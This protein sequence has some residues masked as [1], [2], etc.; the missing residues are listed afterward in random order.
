M[1]DRQRD[2]AARLAMLV[3]AAILAAV[4]ARAAWVVDE[5]GRCVERW[6]ADDWA[7]GP[8]AMLD[9]P[10]VPV[11]FASDAAGELRHSEAPTAEKALYLPVVLVSGVQAAL[12]QLFSGFADTITAGRFDLTETTAETL[13]FTPAGLDILADEPTDVLAAPPRDH[14]GRVIGPATAVE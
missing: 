5:Q 1:N 13:A 11:R 12:T 4:P 7:D 6:T 2:E 3:L 10:I 9:A 14:C 8:R